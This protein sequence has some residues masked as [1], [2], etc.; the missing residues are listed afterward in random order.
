MVNACTGNLPRVLSF[1][2]KCMP[3][4]PGIFCFMTWNSQSPVMKKNLG[5]FHSTGTILLLLGA[6]GKAYGTATS[7]LTWSDNK[8]GYTTVIHLAIKLSNFL[9]LLT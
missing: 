2:A 7:S 4:Q 8:F 5:C 3:P 1:A 6:S 9:N